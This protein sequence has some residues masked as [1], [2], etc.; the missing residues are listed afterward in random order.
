MKNRFTLLAIALFCFVLKSGAQTFSPISTFGYNL[1]AVAENTTAL[2]TTGGAIDGSNYV[3][4]SAAYA[5]IY[6]ST[7]GL[8]NSGLVASGTR[9]YQLQAY[10]ANNMLY[11]PTGVTDSISFTS[12]APYSGISLLCFSTEGNGVMTV[13]LRFTDNSTQ[14]F[15]SQ[16]LTD[17]FGSGSTVISGF[18]RCGRNTGTPANVG[19]AGNPKMYS[20]DLSLTCANRLKNL[21]RV[22]IQNT[23]TNPRDCIMAVSGAAMPSFTA[24]GLP[25]TCAGGSNG[26]ATVTA[27]GGMPP[28]SYTF[29]ST[30]PQTGT[31]ASNL[32]VGIY[33]YTATDAASCAVNGTFA[34]TQSLTP[35][36]PV[37]ISTNFTAVCAGSPVTMACSG[38]NTY[39]WLSN[40]SN[41]TIISF[42]PAITTT[43]SISAITAF[44]C[45]ITGSISIVVNPI[46]VITFSIPSSLCIN[47]ANIP[48]S[49]TP[50]GGLY[51]G[52]GM[53]AGFFNPVSAGV[54]T[55][56]ISYTYTD[57]NNCTAA[58][59]NTVVVNALP[60]V[61]FT[62]NPSQ[63]CLNA[64]A[65]SLTASPNGG[66]FAGTGITGSVFSPTVAGVG[67]YSASYSYTD[68]NG[69]S[70]AK[71]SSITVNALPTVSITSTKKFFCINASNLF[72]NAS[73]SGGVFTGPGMNNSAF[74][75]SVAGVGTPTITYTYTDG[76]NC[77]ASAALVMTVSACT[78]IDPISRANAF[79]SLF[80]NP[81][82]GTF[83]LKGSQ[84]SS[85][86]M[87]NEL[88]QVVKQLQLNEANDFQIQVTDLA[89]GLYF[90]SGQ[91]ENGSFNVKVLVQH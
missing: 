78:G 70:A 61:A 13:T 7:G 52:Q 41:A 8:P 6:S 33:S 57:A 51:Q 49:A 20:L 45:F 91:S 56:T 76:N 32:S 69:C 71:N 54:G 46:P 59:I 10:T 37:S 3:L 43:Y 15:T 82:N 84:T 35:Q 86:I 19:S 12:P 24:G 68:A 2:A 44:N 60:V 90:I 18:D 16:N 23:G 21:Q 62:I 64:A 85:I 88:G 48:L 9:T 17:W 28:Y 55:K 39:T 83:T 31:S 80:P 63:L 30:P 1:D 50:T 67:T 14:V 40:N 77:S 26:G 29:A 65:L 27:V 42:T 66:V 34:V 25:V 89:D 58:V 22:I 79:I 47:A 81:N 74:S 11:V 36:A 72:L 73:P 4:Y 87:I 5:A 75:P 53:V 38:A